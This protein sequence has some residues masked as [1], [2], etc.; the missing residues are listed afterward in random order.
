[1]GK[2]KTVKD[3][4]NSNRKILQEVLRAKQRETKEDRERRRNLEGNMKNV[5]IGQNQSTTT[6]RKT[7]KMENQSKLSESIPQ[8][9]QPSSSSSSHDVSKNT[10]RQGNESVFRSNQSLHQ[11]LKRAEKY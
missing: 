9:S 10:L 4:S 11:S 7:K 2:P 3:K 8:T 5:W 6:Q 1:M